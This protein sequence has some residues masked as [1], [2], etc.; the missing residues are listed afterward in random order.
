MG[1]NAP[2]GRS[3]PKR[4]SLSG[5]PA[6]ADV[7]EALDD[8]LGRLTHERRASVHTVAAYRSD[9]AA[10]FAFMA[11]HLG[12]APALAELASLRVAD[13][14]SYLAHRQNQGLGATSLARA[15]SAVRSF[16]GFLE[17]G[18]LVHTP[19]LAAVRTPKRPR[20][21]PRPLAVDEAM[22][23]IA[24]AS[25][26]AEGGWVR[27]RDAA[28]FT[29]LYGCGLRISEALGLDR[30]VLPLGRSLV[31]T[32]KGAKQRL[33][34]VLPVVSEAVEAYAAAAPFVLGPADP[35]FVGVR[36]ARLNAGIVQKR[37]RGLRA[38]LGLPD[39]ATP[40]ALRHSFA[41]HL[42][43]GGG[44][45]RSIQ[46]LLGHASLGTTQRYTEVDASRIMEVYDAAHP[47]AGA[48]PQPRDTAERGPRR[49]NRA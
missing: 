38:A 26:A 25:C 31:V 15:L 24:E 35:L 9:L 33:V 28:I 6:A 20:A 11:D 47:R 46:E 49:G 23:L 13:F 3:V 43:A 10:F 42:L 16:F 17:R 22:E 44:D 40:H 4:D 41:T 8:W 1:S 39:S 7:Q 2:H 45:L 34:P 5:L 27:L 14:R 21:V 36:G 30:G 32:G 12:G 19:A 18:G 29:L 48:R 37:M